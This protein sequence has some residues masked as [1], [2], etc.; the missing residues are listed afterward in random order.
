MK[1]NY[2][3]IFIMFVF[4]GYICL[5]A[6]CGN[7]E[8]DKQTEVTAK[9]NINE[10]SECFQCE[11]INVTNL[12]VGEP[13]EYFWSAPDATYP[14]S[15][16]ENPSFTF[17][18][19]GEFEITLTVSNDISMDEITKTVIVRDNIEVFGPI[20][21]HKYVAGE[22]IMVSFNYLGNLQ[23]YGAYPIVGI[24][25]NDVAY[26]SSHFY[27]ELFASNYFHDN[28]NITYL[29]WEVPNALDD[30]YYRLLVINTHIGSSC[31]HNIHGYSEPFYIGYPGPITV[32]EA[33][34]SLAEST[35]GLRY[36]ANSASEVPDI[37]IDVIEENAL[38]GSDIVFLIDNTGSMSDDI[39]KVK[40]GLNNIIA[41]LPNNVRIAAATYN[42]LNVEP[43]NWY[44]WTDLTSSYYSVENFINNI[45]VFSGGDDPE[46]VYDGIYLTVDYMTWS[47]SSKRI[48]IVI[49]DAP[50]LEGDLTI[51]NFGQVVAKCK[52]MSI[53]VNLY[54]ILIKN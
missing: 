52:S 34:D 35:G 28:G 29:E 48:I 16:A 15:N 3:N 40:A 20:K 14:E 1:T 44:D 41:N 42:D 26:Q 12:S 8:E 24:C 2:F 6:A 50:P 30:G 9:F 43:S 54:P 4:C 51:Y 19:V 10:A 21:D 45:D 32:E 22:I 17:P 37:I 36:D 38:V 18:Q 49:G 46:S 11:Y 33:F 23:T 13:I 53:D 31:E 7:S 47:S 5:F 25:D 39:A 27:T